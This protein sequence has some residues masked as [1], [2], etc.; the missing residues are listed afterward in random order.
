MYK[1]TKKSQPFGSESYFNFRD[2]IPRKTSYIEIRISRKMLIAIIVSLILHGLLL[3]VF[4]RQQILLNN[5][6][7][8][9]SNDT[10]SVQLNPSVPL[11][12]KSVASLPKPVEPVPPEPVQ[13]RTTRAAHQQPAS[14]PIMTAIQPAPTVVAQPQLSPPP[15]PTDNNTTPAPTDMTSY[16]NMIRAQKRAAA[17]EDDT[18]KPNANDTRMANIKRNLQG[19]GGIFQ[20]IRID[21]DAGSAEFTFRGWDNTSYS[22]PN[23]T[24]IYVQADGHTDI[25]HA[26]VR[27]MI[28]IIRQKH[29]G[30]FTWESDRLNRDVTLSARVKDNAGLEAFMLKEFFYSH[31]RPAEQ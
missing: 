30:D 1:K 4:I 29:D 17:G 9:A 10:L 13:R 28:A 6:P 3:Y 8:N 27:K 14:K 18:P 19:G 15:E 21:E 20:I 7:V 26:I 11:P 25:E 23:L 31:N 24:T 2:T 5:R 16:I 22:N 12:T